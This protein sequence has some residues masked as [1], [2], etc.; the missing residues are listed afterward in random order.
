LDES[1]TLNNKMFL[2]SEIQTHSE[3]NETQSNLVG[4]LM[5]YSFC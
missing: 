5:L 3:E 4:W 2:K 1:K